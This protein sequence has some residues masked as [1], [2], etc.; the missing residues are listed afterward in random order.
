ML[1]TDRPIVRAK[2]ICSDVQEESGLSVK[3]NVVRRIMRKVLHMSY[4]IA[5]TIPVQGN[6]ERCLVLRQQYALRILP[7]LEYGRRIIN[8][9]ESWI[10]RTRYVRK[11]WVPTDGSATYTDK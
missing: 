10:N 2:Q 5:R 7:L 9:D 1:V 11:L 6:S 3:P 8:D 4:R